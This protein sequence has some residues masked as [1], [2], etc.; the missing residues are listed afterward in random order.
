MWI[1]PVFKRFLPFRRQMNRNEM[2]RKEKY[3]TLQNG[4]DA[5]RIAHNR[6]QFFTNFFPLL[7]DIVKY[8]HYWEKGS[9]QSGQKLNRNLTLFLSFL[10]PLLN[11]KFVSFIFSP[12]S[13][14]FSYTFPNGTSP[15]FHP[16]DGY[17]GFVLFWVQRASHTIL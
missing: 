2:D 15:D 14:N 1:D 13:S 12:V 10:N 3:K 9:N 16:N 5:T 11:S 4:G 17:D 6:R 7:F 8:R